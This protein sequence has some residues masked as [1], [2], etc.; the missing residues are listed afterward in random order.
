MPAQ[1]HLQQRCVQH[2][3][4]RCIQHHLVSM[5]VHAYCCPVCSHMCA[6]RERHFLAACSVCVPSRGVCEQEVCADVWLTWCSSPVCMVAS[7]CCLPSAAC[8]SRCV[9]MH[10]V[11]C[12]RQVL[13]WRQVPV[14]RVCPVH[15][16]G[17]ESV[18][19]VEGWHLLGNICG[20]EMS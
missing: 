3:G 13:V 4:R 11:C 18:S 17:P 20:T 15:T 12:S 10:T 16:S 7:C 14:A 9:H 6:V 1:Q 5:P 8:G 19:S 2:G